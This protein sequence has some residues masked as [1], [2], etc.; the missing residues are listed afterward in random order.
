MVLEE[1]RMKI[2]GT[3]SELYDVVSSLQK[4]APYFQPVWKDLFAEHD[5]GEYFGRLNGHNVVLQ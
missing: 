2:I 1:E 3:A 5:K 4:D